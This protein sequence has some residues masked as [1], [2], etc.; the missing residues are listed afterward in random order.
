MKFR[1]IA[2]RAALARTR[3]PNPRIAWGVEMVNDA[4]NI[5]GCLVRCNGAR[6]RGDRQ[7]IQPGVKQRHANCDRVI[8]SRVTVDNYFSCHLL[9][10]FI[11]KL[12]NDPSFAKTV[13]LLVD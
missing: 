9:I 3:R 4:A 5:R 11:G 1:I 2:D 10:L 12:S 13:I 8:D 6:A 7:Y